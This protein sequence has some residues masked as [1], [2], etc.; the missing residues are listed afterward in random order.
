MHQLREDL[1]QLREVNRRLYTLL[2]EQP[3]QHTPL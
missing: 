1:T 3:T 2:S